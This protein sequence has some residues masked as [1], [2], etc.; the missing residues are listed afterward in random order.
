MEQGRK[1]FKR[2]SSNSRLLDVINY[3]SVEQ[4]KKLI[5]YILKIDES[6]LSGDSIELNLLS[7][8]KTALGLYS[9]DKDHV[10]TENQKY[11]FVEYFI[12]DRPQR[13]I[14]EDLNITQQGVSVIIYSGLKRVQKY[15]SNEKINWMEWTEL[16]KD[17]ILW[18]YG[19]VDLAV[20][21]KRLNKEPSKIVSMYYYLRSKRKE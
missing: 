14:A 12:N 2:E 1:C 15:L 5:S 6:S 11:V 16:Q 19:V 9:K 17:V 10:L 7:D 13:Q 4:L 3:G 21:S 20:L 18:N 8:I